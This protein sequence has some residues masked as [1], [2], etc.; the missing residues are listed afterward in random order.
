M[1]LILSGC[2][3]SDA[4][5]QANEFFDRAFQEQVQTSPETLTW[6]GSRERYDEW[7]EWSDESRDEYLAL[8]KRQKQELQAMD[9]SALNEQ[10]QLSYDLF[11]DDVN[12]SIEGDQWRYYG[13][14]V[15]QMFGVQADAP[16]LLINMHRI[17]SESDAEAYIA[18]LEK[19]PRLF[20]QVIAF[21][22]RQQTMG[23][24]PPKFV[25]PIVTE[26]IDNLISGYPIQKDSE[27]KNSL[28]EDFANKLE[29]IELDEARKEALVQR[30]KDALIN[31]VRPAYQSL[32]TALAELEA[33]A[34]TDDGVWKLP[35][36]DEYYKRR[37]K[38]Y[39]TTDLTAEEI[40]Q[41]G[42]EDTKRIHNEMRAIM[43]RVGFEG[44]LQEFFE[45]VRTDSK[46]F[47]PETKQGRQAYLKKTNAFIA[48]VK[49]RLDELF[50]TKPKADLIVKAVEPY[51]EAAAGKAFYSRPSKDG[52]RP[53][54]YYVNLYLMKDMPIYQMEA[55]AY[56]EALPGH[57][58]QLSI[59]SELE[60]VPDFRKLGGY[61]AYTE[62]WGLYS[63]QVPKEIGLY[64]DP[65][66][67][68]G[69][70]AMELW[71]SG[72][73]VVDTGLH[74]KKWTRE[75]AIDWLM[76]N[77]PNPKGDTDKAIE[78]YIVMP[79]QATAYK[80]GMMKIL[81]L[82]EAAREQLGNRFD[83]REFHEVVL[84]NGPLPLHKLQEQVEAWVN[85]TKGAY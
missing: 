65:Y 10:N 47:Y 76:E 34:T 85:D 48:N 35:E 66:S 60:G 84:Q 74:A 26:T 68:F 67:D 81:E 12:Q 39:T 77:T 9:R 3:Q 42:L 59:A 78:R 29:K 23:I 52:S 25:Y 11:M 21:I 5:D 82:R 7:D 50:I 61:T 46:F 64:E 45:Y 73:L 19:M 72:R 69:R 33:K 41:R 14:P 55:L 56:H 1:A 83:L 15:N 53:G 27:Q 6:L 13:Y 51:R 28:Y 71:R 40:H 2:V 20:G 70:L 16:S 18:R 75:R 49:A 63:E 79:G 54:T 17:E 62:G 22:K 57:H 58:M 4:N 44:S 43:R 24:A 36:G 38:V 30:A 31:Q 37:L 80:I 8:L 32:A